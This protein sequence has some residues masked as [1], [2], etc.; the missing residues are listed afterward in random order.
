MRKRRFKIWIWIQTVSHTQYQQRFA[1]IKADGS[2][3]FG[4]GSFSL[5]SCP[6][7]ASKW[8]LTCSLNWFNENKILGFPLLFQSSTWWCQYTYIA[9][10]KMHLS[11]SKWCS[12][13]YSCTPQGWPALE[14]AGI[15]HTDY[16]FTCPRPHTFSPRYHKKHFLFPFKMPATIRTVL[17]L[18]GRIFSSDEFS[19][20]NYTP[21]VCKAWRFV[22]MLESAKHAESVL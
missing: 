22:R 13:A 11:Q 3:R 10:C 1:F 19:G 16:R 15:V 6:Y 18:T 9:K 4:W 8:V 12:V 20:I 7:N 17:Q 21:K 2:P 5:N 14:K